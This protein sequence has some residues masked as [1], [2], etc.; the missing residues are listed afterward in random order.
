MVIS[1]CDCLTLYTQ[2]PARMPDFGRLRLRHCVQS[3]TFRVDNRDIKDTTVGSLSQ[4]IT[5]QLMGLKG[6]HSQL[7]DIR[8]Y[9]EK[10]ATGKI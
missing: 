6:L 10:V 1:A 5:N 4:R 3:N 2:A 7:S 8:N 9:L